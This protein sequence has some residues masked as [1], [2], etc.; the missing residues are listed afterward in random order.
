MQ[1]S[2]VGPELMAL[3]RDKRSAREKILVS[4]QLIRAPSPDDVTRISSLLSAPVK[5]GRI[6]ATGTVAVAD[7]DELTDLPVVRSVQLSRRLRFLDKPARA[8]G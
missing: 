1:I 6:V 2:K 5:K 4:V 8:S 7:L 3:V